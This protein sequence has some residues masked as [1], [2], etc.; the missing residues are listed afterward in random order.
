MIRPSRA[1]VTVTA[2]MATGLLIAGCSSA[3]PA[4]SDSTDVADESSAPQQEAYMLQQAAA[5]TF[6]VTTTSVK[7]TGFLQ[8]EFTC[9]GADSSPHIGWEEVPASTQSIV[10][11]AEDLDLAGEVASHWLVWGLPP[12]TR[13]LPAGASV[14]GALPAGAEEGVNAYGQPG[15]KGPCP[16]PKVLPHSTDCQRS[17]FQSDPYRWSVYAVEKEVSL[18]SDATRDDLLRAIDG[19]ILASGALDI[20]YISKTLIRETGCHG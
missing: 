15:Y 8:T 18:R 14:S 11:V 10:V 13:E 3:A 9:E 7:A 17:G 16:P 6:N 20:K 2:C 4:A 5:T 1:L 19:S 12:D